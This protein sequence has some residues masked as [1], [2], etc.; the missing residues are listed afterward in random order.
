[1]LKIKD[2]IDLKELE[3]FGFEY[4]ETYNAY[5]K[6]IDMKLYA[7]TTRVFLNNPNFVKRQIDCESSIWYD[8][9]FDDDRIEWV[10][11]DI[12]EAGL[13]EKINAN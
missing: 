11:K 8:T 6:I 1:M 9:L 5:E 12:V 4:S 13:V 3:K 10:N 7:I 2:E